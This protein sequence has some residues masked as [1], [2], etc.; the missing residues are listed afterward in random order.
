MSTAQKP[1]SILLFVAFIV[2]IDMMGIGL[3]LPCHAGSDSRCNRCNG[4]P[5]CGNW[6]LAAICL[7]VMQFLFAPIIGGL[8]DR[9]GQATG[10][11]GNAGT[12]LGVD[13][14]IMAWAPN[15][16][17]VVY[18]TN[19]FGDYGRQLGGSQ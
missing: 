8:S 9:F 10:L 17:L 5:G 7:C 16:D 15:S 4:R 6:R 3:I 11:A 2:F 1:Q 14:A 12:L 18:R 13:Y 19:H